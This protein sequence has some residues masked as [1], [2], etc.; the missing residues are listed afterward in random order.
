[1]H[2]KEDREEYTETC[3]FPLSEQRLAIP[4]GSLHLYKRNT[5]LHVNYAIQVITFYSN[6]W[7]MQQKTPIKISKAILHYMLQENV[8][9][10]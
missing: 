8:F 4:R 2:N 9:F 5:L 6:Y 3:R 7:F 10:R 1:M